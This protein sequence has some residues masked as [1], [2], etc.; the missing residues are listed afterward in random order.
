MK[1]LATICFAACVGAA[2]AQTHTL[3][4]E[5]RFVWVFGWNLSS[6]RN[7]QEMIRVV[8]QASKAGLNG[9][10]ASLSQDTLCMQPPDYF[11]RLAALKEACQTNQLEFIPAIFSV[12]YGG[13]VLTHNRNL[14][15]GLPVK[16]AV[17][18]VRGGQAYLSENTDSFTNGGF[19]QYQGPKAA[20]FNLQDEPGKVSFIDT[21][22]RRSGRASVRLE[23]F[24]A[25]PAGN[26][27]VMQTIRVKP[28]RCYR[29]AL[30]AKTEDLKPG[31]RTTVLASGRDLA[32]RTFNIPPTSDWRQITFL[33][34]SQEHD[35]V[36]VYVGVWGGNEGKLWIDDWSVTEVG[37]VNVLKRRGAPSIVRSEDGT[38]VFE[39]GKDYAPLQP[40]SPQPY[41]DDHEP[42]SLKVLP[43]SRM[44]DGSRIKVSWYHSMLIYDSQVTVCMAEPEV[45]EIFDHE[46]KL[47]AQHVKPT[48]VLLN[49]DEVRMG[50]TCRACEGR[51]MAEL[52]GSCVRRQ[53]QAVRKYSP[54]AQV[55]VWSDMFDPNHNA[56]PK[57]YLVKGD[58]TG[59]WNHLPKDLAIAVWGGE[60]RPKSL[61]FFAEKG[62]PTL[63]GCYYDA[64]D[65]G[66]VKGWL[67]LAKKTKGVRGLMY[68]PWLKKYDLLPEFGALLS[69]GD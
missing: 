59:S 68:T 13:G 47:L 37:P 53:A 8:Q 43:G 41:R 49:M 19:E 50:G 63:I 36:S 14:A 2:F 56:K 30:W 32:P 60:P 39:E 9:A 7:L 27:R 3:K 5:D 54:A 34:N 44:Q 51:D 22:I 45:D 24:R 15:E 26:G 10:V 12:G 29:V 16:D 67:G 33:F 48:K 61:E 25:Q 4:F 62:F 52:L 46:A 21:E 23:N 11:R 38:T 28:Y 66:E 65:L 6:D 55:Y 64:G 35:S 42:I 18:E 40:G 1:T 31:L 58:Y 69:T 17:F 20:F 57:Y